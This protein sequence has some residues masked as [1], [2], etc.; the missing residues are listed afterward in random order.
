[1]GKKRRSP[2]VQ[3]QILC[4]VL[5]GSTTCAATAQISLEILSKTVKELLLTKATNV[6]V[7]DNDSNG[8][9][10]SNGEG[11]INVEDGTDDGHGIDQ[12]VEN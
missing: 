2:R 7:D 12:Q 9:D 11:G 4:N 8:G 10:D 6:N 5:W 3:T 1:M